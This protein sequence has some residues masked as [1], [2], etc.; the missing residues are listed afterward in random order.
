MADDIRNYYHSQFRDDLVRFL[1]SRDVPYF[2]HSWTY[3]CRG[4]ESVAELHRPAFLVCLYFTVLVDQAMHEHFRSHYPRFEA[5][6]RYPKFC[7]GLGQFHK[8]PRAILVTPIE[9]GLVDKPAL[10]AL[11]APGTALF[12]SEIVSF[13]RD[14]MPEVTSSDFLDKLAYDRDVQIPEIFV[15]LDAATKDHIEYKAYRALRQAIE[16][17]STNHAL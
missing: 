5:L 8:N 7:H 6:T 9:N 3:D 13:F 10:E 15:A 4:L 12:V 16:N 14:H 11:L 2:G 1:P 17:A